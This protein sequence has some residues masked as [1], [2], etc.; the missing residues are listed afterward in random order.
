MTV[1]V[2]IASLLIGVCIGLIMSFDWKAY[3]DYKFKSE[4]LRLK[5]IME[6][7]K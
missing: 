1:V 3:Y 7:S 6:D 2:G 5:Y 4:E